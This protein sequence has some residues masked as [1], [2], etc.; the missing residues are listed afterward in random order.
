MKQCID[1]YNLEDRT[2]VFGENIIDLCREIAQTPI[3]RPLINQIMRSGT[4]IGANYCEANNASSKKDFKNKIFIC[5]KETQET[6]YWLRM[7][8][9]SEPDKRD[10][11]AILWKECQELVMIFQKIINTCNGKTERAIENLDN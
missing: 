4:S 3:T 1:K 9:K 5:K 11:I 8:V 6:K 10:D 2:A 7:L